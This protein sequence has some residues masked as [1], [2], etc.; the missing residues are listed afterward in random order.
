MAE[1]LTTGNHHWNII[2]AAYSRVG[3]GVIYQGGALYFTE[4]FAG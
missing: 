2:N 1:P 4:D 3:L